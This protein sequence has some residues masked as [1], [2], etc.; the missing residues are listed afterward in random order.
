M[1]GATYGAPCRVPGARCLAQRAWRSLRAKA[2]EKLF[3]QGVDAV[4]A[5]VEADVRLFVGDAAHLIQAFERR[6][7]GGERAAAVGGH[8]IDEAVEG[9]V[10][11]DRYA[12]LID[13]RA[14]LQ[15][16]ERAAA[17]R[18]DDV[19]ASELLGDDLALDG[20]EVGLAF[21]REDVGD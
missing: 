12:V 5:G 11:P 18:D 16:G 9:H 3:D 13:R 19:A 14:V 6:A 4:A 10:E 21:T 17:G 2:I 1:W 7:I 8:A 20:P 15:V